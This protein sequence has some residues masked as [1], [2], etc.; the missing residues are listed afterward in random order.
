MVVDDAIVI[1]DN[2]VE[3]L[4]AG[5]ERWTAAWRS[6]SDLLLPVFGA[7][8]TIIAS[9]MPLVI[10]TGTVGEFIHALPVT[11]AISL[12]TSFAVAMVFTPLLCYLFIKKGLHSHDE[13]D[14][15]KKKS[16]LLDKMQSGYDRLQ[17][18]CVKHPKTNNNQQSRFRL[19]LR[20]CY[21]QTVFVKSFF[22]QQNVISL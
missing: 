12:A 18:W 10:L 17:Q 19:L 21:L 22:L 9:F 5:V 6:A 2:Y 16:S 1:A 8:I 14:Q 4:D 11:V 20:C 13:K 15:K 7:T 3:L